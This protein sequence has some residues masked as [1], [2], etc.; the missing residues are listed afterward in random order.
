M[1]TFTWVAGQTGDWSASANWTSGTLPDSSASVLIPSGL[2]GYVS[3]IGTA[4]NEIINALTLGSVTN[5]LGPT[6]EIG[7]TL[8]IA[9][10]GSALTFV[11]GTIQVD[12]T[13]LFEGAA[14]GTFF[15]SPFTVSFINKAPC[16]PTAVPGPACR[17]S[18]RSPTTVRC[19]P[20]MVC[21]CSAV[22]VSAICPVAR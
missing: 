22:P 2:T 9:G 1:T 7:G 14:V 15:S 16:A 6:L 20:I 18:A 3:Q 11:T 21:C 10:A 12:S 13:G 5:V 17:F 8:Q 4:D 19:S